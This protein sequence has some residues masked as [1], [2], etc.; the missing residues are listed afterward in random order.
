MKCTEE[1]LEIADKLVKRNIALNKLSIE[2]DFDFV[3]TIG[4]LPL[5]GVAMVRVKWEMELESDHAQSLAELITDWPF[6]DHGMA[7]DLGHFDL[8]VVMRT[9]TDVVGGRIALCRHSMT[10]SGAGFHARA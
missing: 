5:A 7:L 4:E 2:C 10:L 1:H 8:P 3:R 6:Q 9:E